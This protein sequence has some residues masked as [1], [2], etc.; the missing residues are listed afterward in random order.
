MFFLDISCVNFQPFSFLSAP[1]VNESVVS[2]FFQIEPLHRLIRDCRDL[3]NLAAQNRESRIAR[4]PESRAR[5][6]QNFRSERRKIQW[7]RSK[8]ESQK[9][10]SESSMLKV[11]L[12][13]HDSESPDSW[14]RILLCL[15]RNVLWIFFS[16]LPGNFAL[17]NGGDFLWIFSGLRFPRDEARK[18]LRKFGENSQRNSGQNS[19]QKFEKFG[20][21]SFCDFSNSWFRIA[22]A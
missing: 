20:E 15:P 22:E 7:K 2:E 1:R 10:D 12:A 3:Q 6:C 14:F 19:G 17:K 8:V 18:L 13:S 9:T 4:F 16:Y 21:L 5:N 11:N